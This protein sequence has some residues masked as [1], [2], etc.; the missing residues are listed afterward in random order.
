M[1]PMAEARRADPEG[2][3]TARRGRVALSRFF[4]RTNLSAWSADQQK[5]LTLDE[6]PT[7]LCIFCGEVVTVQYDSAE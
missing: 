5:A 4:G 2:W 6:V 1:D 3:E 7:H